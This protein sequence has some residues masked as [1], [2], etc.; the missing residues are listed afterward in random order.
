MKWDSTA[1]SGKTTVLW[2]NA[3]GLLLSRNG[4]GT[5]IIYSQRICPLGYGCWFAT[6]CLSC[7]LWASLCALIFWLQYGIAEHRWL[8]CS[9]M[10]SFVVS[11]SEVA[12]TIINPGP[13]CVTNMSNIHVTTFIHDDVHYN[14]VSTAT[15]CVTT[16]MNV[17]LVI[18]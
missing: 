17:M 18:R 9:V 12:K 16:V 7:R 5:C 6:K 3:C 8:L 11:T 4:S 1:P 2:E 14:S 13:N 15:P 10:V